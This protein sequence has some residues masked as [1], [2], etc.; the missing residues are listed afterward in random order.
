MTMIGKF[1]TLRILRN[2]PPGLYLDGGEKGEI[3]MPRRY[4]PKD[5]MLGGM[6]EVFVYR[7]SEDRLVA[8]TEK[9]LGTVG[10][11]VCLSVVGVNRQI[12][13]FLDWGL[14]KDLLLPF[15]EHPSPLRVGQKVLVYISLDPASDRIVATA[16][17]SRYVNRTPASYRPGEAVSL[18]IAS[19]TLLGY[20][21]LI[22]KAHLG[23]LFT[24]KLSAT[25]EVG[26]QVRGFVKSVHPNGKIDLSLDASGYQRVRSL[27]H[28]IL[29]ALQKSGGR[30]PFDDDS[31]P[32]VIR[33]QFGVSKKA[34]KQA[35]GSLYKT[36]RIHF[37]KPGIELLTDE[38][39]SPGI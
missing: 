5:V 7:D 34:F 23:L 1:N 36:R 14:G 2:A 31:P 25:L 33:T 3:L 29:E 10:D 17:L 20:N 32:Q 38:P 19:R 18:L 35:L 8:T 26:Q 6:I 11:F 28:Q 4:I 27:T 39:W 12:G 15:S 24:D 9:P 16:R 37:L 30:L 21:V 13:V 22:E